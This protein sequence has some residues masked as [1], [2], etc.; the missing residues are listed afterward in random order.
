MLDPAGEHEKLLAQLRENVDPGY[1]AGSAMVMKTQMKVYG[2][3][4]PDLRRIAAG[5]KADHRQVASTDLLGLADG[6]WSGE[7]LE[8]RTL[9]NLL[10]AAYPKVLAG[11]PWRSFDRWRRL[12]DNW[13]V[14]DALGTMVL[15]PWLLADPDSRLHHL[16][17]L[18]ADED[19]WSRRLALVATV[20]L[21]RR[22]ASAVPGLTLELVDRVKLEREPMVTKAVSWALRE[23]SKG[24]PDRVAAYVADNR[25]LLASHVVREVQNKLATGLKSGKGR[26]E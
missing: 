8:E 17:A 21:N 20:P 5:W 13:G 12:V 7:S 1:Q 26:S 3:R 9:A 24:E 23:L 14:G 25:T 4:V 15:G 11:I 18:I 19:L 6:L 2:V 16:D 22:A 10:L